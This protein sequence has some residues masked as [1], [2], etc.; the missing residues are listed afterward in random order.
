MFLLLQNW[1]AIWSFLISGAIATTDYNERLKPVHIYD[2]NCSGTEANI[3]ECPHNTINNPHSCLTYYSKDASV[4]C[5][6]TNSS[7]V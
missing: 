3:L 2:I 5:Q 6:G 1:A 7:Y 4:Q